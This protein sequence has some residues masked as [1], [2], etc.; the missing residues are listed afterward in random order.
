MSTPIVRISRTQAW[1]DGFIRER[2]YRCHYCNRFAASVDVGP[3]GKPWHVEHMEALA[4][5][6]ADDES[7]LTLSCERCNSLKGVLS[8]ENFKQ[9]AAA[10]FWVGEPKRIGDQDLS[11]LMAAYLR[12][13]DGEWFYA[14]P[15]SGGSGTVR[16]HSLASH[17]LGI[18]SDFSIA[19]VSIRGSTSRP[20]MGDADFI[21]LAHRLMPQLVAEVHMLRAELTA[22][23]SDSQ[24]TPDAA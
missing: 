14:V 11:S 22:A 4:N 13:T 1:R 21:V 18:E 15:E 20:A 16:L 2:G 9:Y 12:S 17:E 24:A 10:L 6:G 8:Y 19:E 23:L 5:G 7:N 3:D